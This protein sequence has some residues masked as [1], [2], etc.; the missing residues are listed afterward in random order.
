[1]EVSVAVWN[2]FYPYESDEQFDLSIETDRHE[3]NG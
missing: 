2:R 1:M 3:Q